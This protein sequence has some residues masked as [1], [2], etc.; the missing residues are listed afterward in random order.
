MSCGR[1][2]DCCYWGKPIHS[3]SGPLEFR[4]CL[5][6]NGAGDRGERTGVITDG[7]CTYPDFGCV[8]FAAVT[9]EAPA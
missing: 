9:D 6:H 1:C 2:R 4:E 5:L 7:M 8:G 3:R